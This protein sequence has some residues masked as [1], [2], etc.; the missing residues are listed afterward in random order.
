MKY[1]IGLTQWHHPNWYDSGTS[2][3][4]SLGTYAKHFSSVEG[5][6]TFYGVPKKTTVQSWKEST[7]SN[8][9]FCFKFPK[10]I[11]H[12]A[13]LRHCSGDVSDFLNV[14]SN[15]DNNLGV[16]WLQMSEKFTADELPQLTAFLQSLPTD[17]T[18]GIEVRHFD[19]FNKS[20]SE[21]Y[22]NQLLMQNNINRVMFDTRTLFANPKS[23]LVSQEALR[24]KPQV[25]LH[26]LA[27]AEF[28]MVRFISPMNTRLAEIELDKWVQKII[29][30][31][32]EG[33]VPYV[34]F[35]T[36]DNAEAPQ[37]AEKFS[38]KIEQCCPNIKQLTLWNPPSQQTRLF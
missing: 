22:F 26:V 3:K 7:P 16:V 32:N 11:S 6:N 18:Y 8:F 15:L 30:W 38:Q 25:P 33:K 9:R 36:P 34:F 31:M 17:F 35:H 14:L 13:C 10:A 1:Y 20:E 27:T 5:N 29:Q 21:K 37:L 2:N 28:P 4:H 24:K 12:E 23:D 19:F